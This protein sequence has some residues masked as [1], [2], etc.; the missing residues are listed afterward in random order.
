MAPDTKEDDED[1]RAEGQIRFSTADSADALT[2]HGDK[3]DPSGTTIGTWP[4]TS[5]TFASF[6]LAELIE[7]LV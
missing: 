5:P 4:S 2:D 6:S 1:G 3:Y 7:L